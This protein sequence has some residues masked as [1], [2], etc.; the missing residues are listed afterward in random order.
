MITKILAPT[1]GSKMSQRSVTYAA[2]LAKQT[3]ASIIL[4]SVID[5]GTFIP[6]SIPS[7]ATPTNIAEPLEDYLKQV[8]LT[9]LKYAAQSCEKIGVESKSVVRSGHPVEEIIKE[10]KKSHADLIV[11][12]SQ[13]RSALKAALLG[14]VTFGVIHKDTK[15]PVLVV[16]R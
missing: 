10:A 12:G 6:Q 1:D 2:N 3:G 14:S 4:L 9:H 7:G 8:S 11:M 13:G 15:I 5:K 16:R